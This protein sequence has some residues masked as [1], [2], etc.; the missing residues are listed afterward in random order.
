[1][2]SKAFQAQKLGFG[3]DVHVTKKDAKSVNLYKVNSIGDDGAVLQSDDGV[4]DVTIDELLQ[5][6]RV[7][8]GKVSEQVAIE[9]QAVPHL[10]EAWGVDIVRGIIGACIRNEFKKHSD[11]LE[12]VTVHVNPQM[13][14]VV[15]DVPAG[16]LRIVA[17]S[18]R[19][20]HKS[21]T[22]FIPLGGIDVAEGKS[23]EWWLQPHMMMPTSKSG[24]VVK[25]PF[26]SPFWFVN[27]APNEKAAN[28]AFEWV[29]TQA[30]GFKVHVPTIVNK[31]DL[32]IGETLSWCFNACNKPPRDADAKK[33]RKA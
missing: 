19:L 24:E 28:M 27:N 10:N 8:K 17:A 33:L 18:Q 14:K 5:H 4:I 3:V 26:V 29:T 20:S 1:M 11:V 2:Y 21:G 22:G 31:R 6:W 23:M 12:K 9:G 25:S 15:G 13:A 16:K 32:K 30:A 7:H